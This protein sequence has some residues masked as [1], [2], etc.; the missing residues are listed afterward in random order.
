MGQL[1]ELFDSIWGL[2]STCYP[3]THVRASLEKKA[4]RLTV[5]LFCG[6]ALGSLLRV[7]QRVVAAHPHA[8]QEGL[9]DVLLH[10]GL[11]HVVEA[12][13]VAVPQARATPLASAGR[14]KSTLR[15]RLLPRCLPARRSRKSTICSRGN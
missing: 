11:N 5:E 7:V 13:G 15:A 2:S 14:P 10:E 9:A 6:G 3:S 8:H 4:T 1:L 12:F